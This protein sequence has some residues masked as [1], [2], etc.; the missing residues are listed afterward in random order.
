MTIRRLFCLLLVPTLLAGLASSIEASDQSSGPEDADLFKGES[1]D[2]FFYQNRFFSFDMTIPGDWH[3]LS[4]EEL[5]RLLKKEG[6]G[7]EEAIESG[8]VTCLVSISKYQPAKRGP[9][10]ELNPNIVLIA[11]GLSELPGIKTGKDYIELFKA[12]EK[13]MGMKARSDPYP[14]QLGGIE[15]WRFDYTEPGPEITYSA[16]IVTVR[17]GYTLGFQLS[18]GSKADMTKLED[19]LKSL[20]FE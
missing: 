1:V 12:T 19:I 13:A 3:V 15:L 17:K 7:G 16:Q 14:V 11:M 18:A 4:T 9:K 10:G 20:H 8:A 5:L 6:T 2:L